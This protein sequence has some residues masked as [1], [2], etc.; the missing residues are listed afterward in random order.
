MHAS[1]RIFLY[2]VGLAALAAPAWG[3]AGGPAPG[4][5]SHALAGDRPFRAQPALAQWFPRL[6]RGLWVKVEGR[7]DGARGLRASQIKIVNG[8]L[9]ESEIETTVA[10]VDSLHR[11]LRTSYGTEVIATLK[12]DVHGPA[13]HRES[14]SILRPGDRIEVEGQMCKDGRLLADEIKVKKAKKHEPGVEPRDDHEVT[15]RIESLDPAAYKI[16]L[17]G[18]P[19][20]LDLETKNKTPV[21][22]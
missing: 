20:Y 11:S 16:V 2:L 7:M 4:G 14:F 12:T 8:D 10:T 18:V 6:R 22:E 17:L 13:K 15:A 1:Q 9:D 19:V 5:Q 3:Q 21:L